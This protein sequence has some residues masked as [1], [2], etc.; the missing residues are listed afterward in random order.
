ML[1][2]AEFTGLEDAGPIWL[3]QD[4]ERI[5]R[6]SYKGRDWRYLGDGA[7]E[8]KP[9]AGARRTRAASSR[10]RRSRADGDSGDGEG[11]D[12]TEVIALLLHEQDDVLMLDD[13]FWS[14]KGAI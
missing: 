14:L 1:G 2:G 3:P 9:K 10:L 4:C 7:W 13:G 6:G 5:W 8:P 11:Q 12:D